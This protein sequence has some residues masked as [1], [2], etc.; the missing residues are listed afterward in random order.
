MP[1]F[2]AQEGMPYW[3]E[4]TSSE[5]RKSTYF[6][7]QLLGWDIADADYR[8]ARASGFPVAGIVPQPDS[9]LLPD[10]WITYFYAPKLQDTIARA[11]ELG[12]RVML[13]PQEVT[14][15][16]IAW[17]ADPSGAL[18]GL[19][20]PSDAGAFVAAGEPSTPVWHELSVTTDFD[21][22]TEFYR[23][24]F[25]WT[26]ETGTGY[27]AALQSGA[28]FAGIADLKGQFPPQVPSFW[29]SYWGVVDIAAAVAK[30]PQL[31]GEVLR[32][33]FDSPFGKLAIIADSTGATVT[34]CEV[35]EY[36]EDNTQEGEDIFA[37]VAAAGLL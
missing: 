28:A 14:L 15:G 5:L 8:I 25:G 21:A 13:P 36:V 31:K 20:A 19:I 10:T 34:L 6:Y 12:A 1:A 35:A 24:L 29:Q 16:T 32:E 23:Q 2:R 7:Q 37:A 33:P 11:E 26:L 4:L 22:A 3:A 30:V 17:L 9:V 18:L 27:A